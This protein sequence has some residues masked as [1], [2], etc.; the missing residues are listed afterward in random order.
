MHSI[1]LW[2]Y[3]CHCSK[4]VSVILFFSI[5]SFIEQAKHTAS[6]SAACSRVILL[7]YSLSPSL[8]FALNRS[9]ISLIV[10]DETVFR[11]IIPATLIFTKAIFYWPAFDFAFGLFCTLSRSVEA[12]EKA[13]I[14]FN[15]EGK[16][17]VF[18][19]GTYSDEYRDDG[20]FVPWVHW[21]QYLPEWYEVCK[22][23]A[24][25]IFI[26]HIGFYSSFSLSL[27]IKKNR[28]NRHNSSKY[29]ILKIKSNDSS[30]NASHI[31]CVSM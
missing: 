23:D 14:T 11:Y 3:W 25:I 26:A 21:I 20:K 28:L 15:S 10:F 2:V 22:H 27:W 16:H 13:R 12:K 5:N 31:V 9:C 29:F 6:Y 1:E 4:C 8:V 30:W 18:L 7:V 17:F 19:R 24:V